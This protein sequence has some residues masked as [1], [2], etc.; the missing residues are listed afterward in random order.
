LICPAVAKPG[1]EIY[2]V[3]IAVIFLLFAAQGFV[4]FQT[5]QNKAI[6]GTALLRFVASKAYPKSHR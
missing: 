2:R 5:V 1:G 6:G 4:E 3:I